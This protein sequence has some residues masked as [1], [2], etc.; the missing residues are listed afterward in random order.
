MNPGRFLSRLVIV[1]VLAL[2]LMGAGGVT[3]SPAD[4]DG[5]RFGDL[6]I[7]V[8]KEDVRDIKDAGAVNILYGTTNGLR[9]A[10]DQIWDQDDISGDSG[11]AEKE[12]FFGQSLAVGDL[13]GDLLADLVVGAP[14]EDIGTAANAGG[15][16]VLYGKQDD[17]LTA[18]REEFWHQGS[19]GIKGAVETGDR[20][21]KSL[22]IG[23]FDGDGFDDLAVGIPLENIEPVSN[24]GAVSVIYGSP[25]GLTGRDQIWY[26][27]HHVGGVAE[28]DDWF[29]DA[30]AVGDF[31]GDGFDDL[32]I[33]IPGEDLG[34]VRNG[35]RVLVLFGAVGGLTQ[36]GSQSWVQGLNGLAN[37]YEKDDYFGKA[38]A[39]GDFDGD[40]YEDLAIG[41]P[42]ENVDVF[43]NAGIVQVLYGSPAGLTAEHDQLWLDIEIAEHDYFGF[44]LAAGDFN[45]DGR[46]DLAVGAPFENLGSVSDAGTV[47]ILYGASGGL[48]RRASND[49]WHQ[50]RPGVMDVAEESDWFGSALAAGNFDGDPYDDLAVGVCGE[51]IGSVENAG[52]VQIFYGSYS[53]VTASRSQFWHQDSPY[54]EGKAE[55]GD[56][57]G[58]SLAAMTSHSPKTI[59]LPM[60]LRRR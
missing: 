3:G 46:D 10:G 18:M 40:G 56:S 59:Y 2:L 38:L 45:G 35:G 4:F 52:A 53:G 30:L 24:A 13:N 28:A 50:D 5:D 57:F 17:G 48:H 22:A 21:G 16:H 60:S 8:Y 11:G 49:Y 1:G 37:H 44:A 33:G 19:P 47:E 31:D 27:G 25:T 54:I 43:V 42:D 12:D 7:G 29:G 26:E 55:A 9:A 36:D 32:A 58:C 34:G 15:V 39:A 51:D 23:D 20:F 14:G 6:A 41:V